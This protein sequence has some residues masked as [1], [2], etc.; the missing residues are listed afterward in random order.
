[1]GDRFVLDLVL[2]NVLAVVVQLL[3]LQAKVSVLVKVLV[4]VLIQLYNYVDSVKDRAPPDVIAVRLQL[5]LRTYL[6]S[7]HIR[8]TI[9][10]L[11]SGQH[12]YQPQGYLIRR[13]CPQLSG[14]FPTSEP[15][16]SRYIH[17][18]RV[19]SG[20]QNKVDDIGDRAFPEAAPVLWNSLP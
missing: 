12:H 15:T 18:T 3:E 5:C 17:G 6:S 2:R 9:S 20:A 13:T 4:S 1:M 7:S 10:V 14:R 19:C 11:C 16:K 8:R